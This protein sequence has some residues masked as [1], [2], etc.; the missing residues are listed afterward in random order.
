VAQASLSSDKLFK[1]AISLNS[2]ANR[3]PNGIALMGVHCCVET[4]GT[5][6]GWASLA[7]LLC[8]VDDVRL[9]S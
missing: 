9:V 3:S 7:R 8:G 2:N 6:L 1:A 5:G 4:V